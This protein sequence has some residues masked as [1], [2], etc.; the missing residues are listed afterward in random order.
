[1]TAYVLIFSNPV[2]GREE[3]CNEWYNN[4][5]LQEVAA[6]EG[7][8]WARRFELSEAQFNPEQE[9]RYL[10]IYEVDDENTGQVLQ[11]MLAAG[12][13]MN[14]SDSLDTENAKMV[15]VSSITDIVKA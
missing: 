12:E 15:V 9:H 5:H 11:N 7:V 8:H 3:E 2:E 14:M 13:T 4:I 6:V 10:A 1:M